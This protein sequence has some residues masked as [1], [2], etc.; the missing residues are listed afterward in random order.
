[1]AKLKNLPALAT[2]DGFK[3]TIDY[4]MWRGIP[5]ARKWPTWHT[6]TPTPAE[7]A[8]QQRFSYANRL[9]SSASTVVKNACNEMAI[10]TPWTGKDLFVKG[11]LKGMDYGD[12]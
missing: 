11:Y 9:W 12:L 7:A 4:Y 2:I 8:N 1:M 6:R 5:C 10:G 3:G